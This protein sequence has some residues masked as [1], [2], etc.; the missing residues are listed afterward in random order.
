MGRFLKTFDAAEYLGV[1]R[2]S[3]TNWAKQG[4]LKSG[5]TPGGHYR[6]TI[7][8]LNSFAARRGLK[9]AGKLPH[10]S[11]TRIL[12]VDDD[13][14]FRAFVKE[15]LEAF[16]GYELKEAE[17]GMQGALVAGSWQPDLVIVDLKM[18]NMNGIDFC[19]S[20]KKNESTS[21]ASI[22]VASAYLSEDARKEIA[23]TGVDVILEKPVRLA[24]LVAALG[25]C[26]NLKLK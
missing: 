17:D 8:E 19:K 11:G 1:S 25:K 6:F 5:V 4:L 15:A 10:A 20:I 3:L 22:I 21:D 23:E 7:E 2:S 12:I 18:P 9:I 13:E 14:V 26:A 24:S 16:D